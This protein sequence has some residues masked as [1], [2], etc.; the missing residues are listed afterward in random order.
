M[1]IRI[2]RFYTKYLI[3][4]WLILITPIVDTAN[5]LF[6]LRYGATGFSI[7]TVYRLL[8][9]IYV[10][11]R[12]FKNKMLIIQFL[13]LLYF[14]LIG[15]A[16]GGDNAFGC[17]T[18]AMKWLLPVALI[19]YYGMG[20]RDKTDIKNCLIRSL[21]FWSIFVP[22][23]LIVE[24]IF[25][26]GNE[27][28]YDAGFKGLYYSTN[29]IAVVL[30]VLF[31]YTLYKTIYIDNKNAVV[32]LFSFIAI[33]ILSTK[34]TVIFALV[35]LVYF[36]VVSKKLK[37]RHLL[38]IA[39]IMIVVWWFANT[40]QILEKFMLR[41]SNMWNNTVTDNWIS[42]FLFFATSGRTS[43]IG[44]MFDKIHDNGLYMSNLLFGWI[45]PDNAHVIEMDWHDLICQYGIIGFIIC[46][47]EYV[48]LFIKSNIKSQ[49]YYY[50]VI[51]CMIYSILAGHV[52]SGAFAGTVLA[53]IFALL[54]LESNE[55]R[56]KR[57]LTG[58]DSLC[59]K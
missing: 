6:L 33:I 40:N 22:V 1:R 39:A 16:R 41:Y 2:K 46:V 48:L 24:Y 11:L 45:Q 25:K 3:D 43:R 38:S 12:L 28:Y 42:N 50:I 55:I 13:P 47:L 53:M 36:L 58:K 37:I 14:P 19:L 15:L 20:K 56:R 57:L 10:I 49:P 21:D 54:L 34:S 23:S 7:G 31:I 5:G 51:V 52:I 30:I 9:L 32:C 59:T 18:Y 26:L 17:F 29:D 4:Y 44:I 35:S 8:L 27:T